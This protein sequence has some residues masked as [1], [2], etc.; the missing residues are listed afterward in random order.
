MNAQAPVGNMS[1]K[2]KIATK[3]PSVFGND[4]DEEA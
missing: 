2:P 3:V 4:S 1:K